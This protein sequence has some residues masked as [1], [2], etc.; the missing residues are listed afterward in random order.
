M[1][2]SAAAPGFVLAPLRVELLR[3]VLE[4]RELWALACIKRNKAKR[5]ML[6]TRRMRRLVIAES[7]GRGK[8][9]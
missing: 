5:A 3:D 8:R 6:A 2:L 7:E 1:E 9:R 4:E